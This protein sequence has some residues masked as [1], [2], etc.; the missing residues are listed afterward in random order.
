MRRNWSSAGDAS[1][2][3]LRKMFAVLNSFF[4]LVCMN[5]ALAHGANGSVGAPPVPHGNHHLPGNTTF[6]NEAGHVKQFRQG[7]SL[8][9]SST[10]QNITVGSKL[11]G[12]S[13]MT[14]DVGGVSTLVRAGSK[15]TPAQFA[16][17]DQ[18]LATGVQGLNL[19]GSGAA[20]G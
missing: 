13:T 10:K 20:T 1:S 18:K 5:P 6:I 7:V 2:S 19:S 15:L 8:D 16:A 3:V 17:L 9:L 12:H 14:I 4:L 11:L